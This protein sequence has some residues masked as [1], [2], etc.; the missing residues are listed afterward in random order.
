MY[1]NNMPPCGH[2]RPICGVDKDYVDTQ[3]KYTLNVALEQIKTVSRSE[4]SNWE[5]KNSSKLSFIRNKP[6]SL[7]YNQT[8]EILNS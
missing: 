5:E 4:Q 2:K 8:I 3:D 1:C 6:D 7:T